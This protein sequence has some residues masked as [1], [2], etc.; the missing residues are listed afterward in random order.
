ME[1][2]GTGSIYL[3]VS[4][5]YSYEYCTGVELQERKLVLAYAFNNN[6]AH[7]TH[8]TPSL[9]THTHPNWE[10]ACL[11]ALWWLS[12]TITHSTL[13]VC[14]CVWGGLCLVSSPGSRVAGKVYGH[15]WK[16]NKARALT[17][18][19]ETQPER[20]TFAVLQ[21][22]GVCSCPPASLRLKKWHRCSVYWS[23]VC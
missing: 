14:V 20:G 11:Q 10:T 15:F 5:W 18:Q 9:Q 16:S 8:S 4:N 7:R 22:W 6:K 23:C 3:G 21:G 2:N 12:V 13:C 19:R 17:P 1:F